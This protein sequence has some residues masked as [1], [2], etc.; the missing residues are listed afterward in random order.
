MMNTDSRKEISSWLQKKKLTGPK[1]NTRA[2]AMQKHNAICENEEKYRQFQKPPGRTLQGDSP[3]AFLQEETLLMHVNT[4]TAKNIISNYIM[5]A[6]ALRRTL[7]IEESILQIDQMVGRRTRLLPNQFINDVAEI[8]SCTCLG[9]LEYIAE[10]LIDTAFWYLFDPEG[11]QCQQYKPYRTS[12]VDYDTFLK[13]LERKMDSENAFF[14]PDDEKEYRMLELFGSRVW[15]LCTACETNIKGECAYFDAIRKTVKH[16]QHIKDYLIE[17]QKSP[18]PEYE[19]E[20]EPDPNAPRISDYVL[21]IYSKPDPEEEAIKKA[22]RLITPEAYD[23][24]STGTYEIGVTEV[25][26]GL[27]DELEGTLADPGPQQSPKLILYKQWLSPQRFQQYQEEGRI[28]QVIRGMH[29][30]TKEDREAFEK[31]QEDQ[32]P[33]NG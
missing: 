17:W 23:G 26:D 29:T 6:D 13:E 11:T 30:W 22:T 10:Q 19:S 8:T 3:E 16:S 28:H 33:G 20:E 12:T 32:L 7:L 24:T 18:T 5:D 27:P 1:G 4:D 2:K 15:S 31:K 14:L 25:G 9:Q 21:A